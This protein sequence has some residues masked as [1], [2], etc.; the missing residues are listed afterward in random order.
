MHHEYKNPV[1]IAAAYSHPVENAVSNVPPAL[2]AMYL[3]RPHILSVNAFVASG[4]VETLMQHSGF[5]FGDDDGYHTAHHLLF[6]YNF[7]SLC[8]LDKALDT[9]R[10]Y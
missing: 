1:A 8:I 3:M 9:Y 10:T 7:G 5:K 6:N 2:V 4:L